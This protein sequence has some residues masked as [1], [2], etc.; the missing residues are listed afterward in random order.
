MKILCCGCSFTK[1]T[2]SHITV[3]YCDFL[4]TDKKNVVNIGQGGSGIGISL[5]NVLEFLESSPDNIS[6]FIFQV[7]SPAR[8]PIK[9]NR[10]FTENYLK[11]FRCVVDNLSGDDYFEN[12]VGVWS[13]LLESDDFKKIDSIFSSKDLYYDVC[14][15]LI[16]KIRVSILRKYPDMKMIFFR[17]EKNNSPLI[18]EFSKHFYKRSLKNYCDKNRIDYMYIKNFN[19]EWFRKKGYTYDETHPNEVGAKLIANKLKEYL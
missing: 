15:E 2:N 9:I 16:E 4:V 11:R 6:H 13:S 5:L 1:R 7:P 14:I 3:S 10:P 12:D 8:Q 19:T 17:Y 18:Y